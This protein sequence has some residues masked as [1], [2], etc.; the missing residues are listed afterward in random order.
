MLRVVLAWSCPTYYAHYGVKVAVLDRVPPHF[1]DQL[2]NKKVKG[3]VF[4]ASLK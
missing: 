3:K 2:Q 4:L 1:L